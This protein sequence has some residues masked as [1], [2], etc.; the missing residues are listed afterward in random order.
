LELD[1]L[2]LLYAG[3]SPCYRVEAGAYGKHSKGYYR[4]HQFDKMEL[5][6]YAKPEESEE[7]LQKILALEEEICQELEIPYRVVRIASGDLSAPAYQKYDI[8]YF[9]PAD[10]QYRELTSCSNCTDFQSRRL[11]I[12]TKTEDER[13][14]VHTLNGTAIAF[15]R[16]FIALVENHQQTDGTVHL[17]K[18]LHAYYGGEV[19]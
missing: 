8:E 3:I 1:A 12:R 10:G 16:V 17:P 13:Q 7:W 6:V 9:S 14:F 11:N 19:L 5:Y 2:P 15:S 4:V 18:A